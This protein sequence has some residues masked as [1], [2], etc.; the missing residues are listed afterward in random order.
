MVATG[1]DEFAMLLLAR[2]ANTIDHKQYTVNVQYN[3][4]VGK[5]TIPKFSDEKLFKSIRDEL[6]MAG[7]KETNKS[8]ADLFLLVNTD[9]FVIG[10]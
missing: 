2:A 10:I 7:A 1:I 6:T 4:G 3:T 5:D 8:N 9:Y